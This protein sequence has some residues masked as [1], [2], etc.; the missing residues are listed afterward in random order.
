M[1]EVEGIQSPGGWKRITID[2]V[3]EI[4]RGISFP[5]DSKRFASEEGYVACLRTANV[6]QEV[7]WDDLWFVPEEFL[8]NKEQLIVESDILIST[9]N[10][11]ELLGKVALVKELPYRSTLGAFISAIRP[12]HPINAKCIYH[13]L[14]SE[15]FKSEVRKRA[16]TTTNISNI[17][18]G[19]L[20]QIS[21]P[22]PPLAEQH[23]IVT[24]IEELFS[25]L[26]NGVAQLRR[27]QAQLKSYRQSV[28]KYVFE[29]KLTEASRQQHEQLPNAQKL[30]TT[31]QQERHTRHQ[32]ALKGWQQSVIRWAEAGKPGKKPT[33]PKPPKE[34]PPLTEEEIAKLPPLPVGWGWMRLGN[35]ADI[36]GGV[37]KG[38]KLEGKETVELPYLRVANVQ[39]GYLDLEQI[40]YIEVLATDLEKYRLEYG[41]ILYTEGGDKDKLGRGTIWRDQVP[42]CIHQNHV[43]RARTFKELTLPLYT[44]YYSQ[45]P[46]AKDYFFRNAKQTVNL[47]S[48]NMTILSNLPVPLCSTV[49][50]HQIVQEIES[51]LSVAEHLEKTVE[52]SLRQ[53]EVLRQS[54]LHRA[55]TGQLVP[56][57][58]N[59]EP[60]TELLKRIQA[61]KA[62][63][64]TRSAKAKAT[65]SADDQL[66]I[67]F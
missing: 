21:I 57:D 53:A 14:C 27:V 6:Q 63:G 61:G 4:I 18:T 29:G 52:N 38:R 64:E 48:I 2:E 40:K 31:I 35:F 16:S 45:T 56:Q 33:K 58:P 34:L 47:A 37:T 19:K 66:S 49:E 42:D 43:F 51:R 65:S 46:S 41:D 25:E 30:L 10:S 7:E 13:L 15:L 5:K 28:L 9:A 12:R 26:D 23:R 50:Q 8:K 67:T 1:K 55:F 59:D 36:I 17:S 3:L 24:K 39:D 44:A 22:L 54:I 32:Q 60:A 62:D 20:K 11:L